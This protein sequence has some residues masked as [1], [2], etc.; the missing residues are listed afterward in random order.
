MV[1]FQVEIKNVA[2]ALAKVSTIIAKFGINIYSGFIT[3]Y[4]EK[5]EALFSFIADT[6]QVSV[7]PEQL[8]E[9]L[10]GL[11]VVLGV[12]LYEPKLKG[13]IT[14]KLHFPLLALGER[15]LTFRV[16]SLAEMFR[17]LYEVFGSAAAF[18]LYQMGSTL[19]SDKVEKLRMSYNL[20][21]EEVLKM[22]LDER[23]AKGWCIPELIEFD[24]A[25]SRV[26][27]RV[28]E[29]FECLP[30]K[31]KENEA[32]SYFFK[33]Y[34]EGVLKKVLNREVRVVEE[35]CIAKGDAYCEFVAYT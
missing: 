23:I 33:G 10:K 16:E 19:G 7:T 24:K 34:L 35:R 17:R 18:I 15:S 6:T 28:Y 20:S 1:E 11:D 4:P 8:I 29:L 27:V 26:V 31:E 30:S 32:K 25:N 9:E 22:I 14:D 12:N 2:D 13:F 3:A 5:P 21:D